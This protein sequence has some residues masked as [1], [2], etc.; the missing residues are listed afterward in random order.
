ML[1]AVND[2]MHGSH[3]AIL[4]GAGF[5]DAL[6]DPM[7][8]DLKQILFVMAVVTVLFLVLKAMFFK[9]VLATIDSRDEAIEGGAARRAEVAALVV[10]R[11]DAYESRLK[12]L[13]GQAFGRRKALTD[14]AVAE[15]QR[16]VADARETAASD[17]AVALDRLNA[18]KAEAR[19]DLERQVDQLAGAMAA[20]LLKA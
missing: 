15:R 13:R 9:P 18:Q 8:L 12:E 5:M 3:A 6:P 20:H 16:L 4:E 19:Q 2:L 11:Q 7:K 10:Q 17:R 1:L 14:A